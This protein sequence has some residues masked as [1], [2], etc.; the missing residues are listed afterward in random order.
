MLKDRG[1]LARAKWLTLD[2]RSPDERYPPRPHSDSQSV[3]T[4][5]L[6]H[7][8][9]LSCANSLSALFILRPES[10]CHH[11]AM[12]L[13]NPTH[14]RPRHLTGLRASLHGKPGL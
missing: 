7:R 14:A 6:S 8:L 10:P 3:L 1:V 11:A 12:W 13:H 2:S 4:S 9:Y 5:S